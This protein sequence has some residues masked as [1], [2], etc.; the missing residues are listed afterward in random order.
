MSDYKDCGCWRF[1]ETD[2][3]EPEKPGKPKN[4]EKP[5]H[6]AGKPAKAEN[7]MKPEYQLVDQDTAYSLT[8][9]VNEHLAKGWKVYGPPH[10]YIEPDCPPYDYSR[11][12]RKDTVKFA[13]CLVRGDATAS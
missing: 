11:G 6:N 13:Q 3:K 8:V 10:I 9:D 4:S 7:H 5:P 12:G 2:S 1:T